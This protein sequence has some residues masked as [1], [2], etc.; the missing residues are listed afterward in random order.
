MR[1]DCPQLKV[2]SPSEYST[3]P[4]DPFPV[5]FKLSASILSDPTAELSM[6]NPLAKSVVTLPVTSPWIVKVLLLLNFV[7]VA[8]FPVV[9]PELPLHCLLRYPLGVQLQCL[10]RILFL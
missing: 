2:P 1:K 8:A 10:P 5:T 3:L 6:A 4:A 7:A 9:L